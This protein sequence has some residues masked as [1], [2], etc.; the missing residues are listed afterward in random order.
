M[1]KGLRES[2]WWMQIAVAAGYALAYMAL[3]LFS[4]AHWTLTSGLRVTCLLLVPYRYW[5]ALVVGEVFPLMYWNYQCLEEFGMSWV[6]VASVPPL[7]MGM[8]LA[9]WFRSRLRI[10]PSRRLVSISAL[11]LLLLLL[12]TVWSFF[13]YAIL[14][15]IPV[16]SQLEINSPMGLGFLLGNYLGAVTIV[17]WALAIRLESH[18][19][20]WR[21]LWRK[22]AGRLLHDTLRVVIPALLL[23]AWLSITM[24]GDVSEVARIA[25]FLPVAWLTL[26]YGWRAVMLGGTLT[27]ICISGLLE[28]RPVLATMQTQGFIAVAITCLYVLGSRISVQLQQCAQSRFDAMRAK[29][30]ARRSLSLGEQRMQQ[31]SRALE[32]LHPLLQAKES[33]H[34]DGAGGCDKEVA[35]FMNPL[36]HLADSIFPSVWRVRG[37]R[38]ALHQTIG[39]VL[40]EA[41]V[42]YHFVAKGKC[43][44]SL[45]YGVQAALYRTACES[46]AYLSSLEGCVSIQLVVRCGEMHDHRWVT[47]CIDGVIDERTAED[48]VYHSV[49][50]ERV[51][52]RLGAQSLEFEDL[53]E[54]VGL[55]NGE[56]RVKAMQGRVRVTA[57]LCDPVRELPSIDEAVKPLPLWVS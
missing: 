23:L 57:L 21:E 35:G 42:P 54:F 34:G 40:S 39:A 24:R 2:A 56:V 10:F 53:R 41:G 32:Y 8:P 30:V 6:L 5:P 14:F 4:D 43:L 22:M 15:A 48:V 33:S 18:V 19:G 26:K 46:I 47:L 28:S 3:R 7:I 16:A 36:Q 52:P 11:L 17:P 55:F 1:R 49:R 29:T 27:I 38:G 37:V 44:D 50:R 31:T 45:V 13:S 12:S 25:M 51:T 20:R 9:W